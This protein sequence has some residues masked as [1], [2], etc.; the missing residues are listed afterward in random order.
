MTSKPAKGKIKVAP[1]K[2]KATPIVR[3]V[4]AITPTNIMLVRQL[5]D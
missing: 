2:A 5:T 4:N 3:Q 1:I